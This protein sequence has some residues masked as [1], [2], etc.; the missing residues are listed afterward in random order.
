VKV[1]VADASVAVIE[2][3]QESGELDDPVG[4]QTTL[5]DLGAQARHQV[6]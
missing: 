6:G 5:C 3:A 1:E 4:R 2:R